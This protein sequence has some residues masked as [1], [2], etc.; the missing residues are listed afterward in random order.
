MSIKKIYI[1]NLLLLITAIIW[2]GSFIYIKI[3]LRE[4]GPFN[5]AFYRYLF[6]T[7]VIILYVIAKNKFSPPK[8][9]DLSKIIVL[10]LTG[11]T[12][13]YVL[14]FFALNFTTATNASILINSSTLFV[15][16]L[17][18]I[19]GERIT[20]LRISGIF[21]AF[22]G[23]M[24]VI[25][26]GSFDIFTSKTMIGDML[27]ISDGFLWALYTLIGKDILKRYDP[28]NL[29]AN[30]FIFGTLFLFPFAIYEDLASPVR[31]S[32]DLLI[33]ILYLSILC[34]VFGYAAWYYVL[35]KRDATIVAAYV[36]LI[37]L[38]TSIMAH[39][40]LQEEITTFTA[41]GGFFTIFG[42]LFAEYGVIKK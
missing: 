28:E 39:Y 29:T 38:F 22:I 34:S 2:A 20:L 4:L 21:I 31:F 41:I 7:P 8:R 12:L 23:M 35:K 9:S 18:V 10:S 15:V 27:M 5:L 19:F 40:F 37:P 3:G 25:S 14:Q 13:L 26:K 24:M 33:S 11:V 30:V 6:A 32:T 42:I 17:T 1:Y 36:Y 16:I